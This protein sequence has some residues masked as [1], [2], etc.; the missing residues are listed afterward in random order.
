MNFF[1]G[2]D[3]SMIYLFTKMVIEKNE[4]FQKMFGL[5]LKTL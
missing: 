3:I 2:P 1:K 5:F 4:T